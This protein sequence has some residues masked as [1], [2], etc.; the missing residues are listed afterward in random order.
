L[1]I[2]NLLIENREPKVHKIE[3]LDDLQ[4]EAFSNVQTEI[5]EITK[6]KVL[7][8]RITNPF[9]IDNYNDKEILD[10]ANNYITTDESLDNYQKELKNNNEMG[11]R[12]NLKL[13]NHNKSNENFS[14]KTHISKDKNINSNSNNSLS[15][16]QNST[17]Y[18]NRVLQENIQKAL[19]FYKIANN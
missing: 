8:S 2:H 13:R 1:K 14:F 11:I 15:N 5:K 18:S 16:N 7:S 12:Y 19:K 10:L 17:N 6:N 9:N 3:C 4:F